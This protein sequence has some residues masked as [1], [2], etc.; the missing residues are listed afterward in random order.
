MDLYSNMA[1]VVYMWKLKGGGKPAN[2]W[3]M[4]NMMT[5]FVVLGMEK[6]I[7]T[8]FTRKD[9]ETKALRKQYSAEQMSRGN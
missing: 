4:W 1:A 9:P 6:R 8:F 5:G 7:P 2:P 3:S